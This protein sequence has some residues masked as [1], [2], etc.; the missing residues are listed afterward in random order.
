MYI[1]IGEKIRELR[2]RDNRKQEDLANAIGVTC[3]AVSRWENETGYPD[4]EI[5]P[6]IANYFHV[7]IDDL[8][9]YHGDREEKIKAILDKAD[10]EIHVPKYLNG[11]TVYIKGL[12]ELV[13]ELRE[14]S[15]EFPNEARILEKLGDALHMLGWEKYGARA[16]TKDDSDYVYHDIDYHSQNEYWQ[17]A[18]RVYEK[19]LRLSPKPVDA[20]VIVL[21]NLYQMTGKYDKAKELAAQQNSI[22]ACREMLLKKTAVGEEAAEYKASFILDCLEVLNSSIQNSIATDITLLKSEYARQVLLAFVNLCETI[23]SDGNCGPW[24]YNLLHLYMTVADYEVRF[25]E[26]IPKALEYFDKCFDHYKKYVNIDNTEFTYTAPI[27]SKRKKTVKIDL[28]TDDFW[29]E[30]MRILSDDLKNELRK[31]AKYAECFI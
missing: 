20:V 26:N 10:R 3:Q 4:M 22:Y 8:F 12:S 27:V 1:K 25:G 21:I 31:N 18:I 19:V 5:I 13:D 7:T 17:E 28:L 14:A 6:S 15:I 16:Y 30:N 2:Q 11:R 9:G 24:H 29:K 23:F